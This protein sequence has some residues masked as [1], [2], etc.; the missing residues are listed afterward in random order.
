MAWPAGHVSQSFPEVVVT[1]S[2]DGEVHAQPVET[3]YGDGDALPPLR[4]P[5]IVH[6]PPHGKVPSDML[7]VWVQL[8]AHIWQWLSPNLDQIV[9]WPQ[10]G[11]QPC[12]YWFLKEPLDVL[13]V[14]VQDFANVMHKKL[15]LAFDAQTEW[16]RTFQTL[17]N[18][19]MFAD[20]ERTEIFVKTKF[21][22][23]QQPCKLIENSLRMFGFGKQ[24]ID[25]Y[26]QKMETVLEKAVGE[27]DA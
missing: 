16:G 1:H 10:I 11:P 12:A 20:N 21:E 22:M 6:H 26:V 4:L 2:D 9:L 7:M 25:R 27:W 13:P 3:W 24:H 17:K 15:G 18:S 14:P 8:D 19:A 5:G 23:M